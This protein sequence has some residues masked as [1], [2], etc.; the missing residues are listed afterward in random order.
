MRC[1]AH[2]KIGKPHE[3]VR[4]VGGF[5]F[6]NRNYWQP[7]FQ[8]TKKLNRRTLGTNDTVQEPVLQYTPQAQPSEVDAL[9]LEIEVPCRS[10][11]LLMRVGF[12]YSHCFFR[13]LFET[14]FPP[15]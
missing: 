7:F 15:G 5:N 2:Q 12:T 11:S 4:R 6:E 13:R 8:Q 9:T 3:L 10:F 1:P 14:T